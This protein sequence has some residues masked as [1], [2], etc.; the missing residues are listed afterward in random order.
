M[1]AGRIAARRFA[2]LDGRGA[3]LHGGRWSS[4]GRPLVHAAST[5]SLA[6]LEM[7][8]RLPT[9][10]VPADYAAIA[11]DVPDRPPPDEV[12]PESLP[13]WDAPDQLAS[14]ACGDAWL[15]EGRSL[16]LL[17]PALAVPQERNVL[18][19][20]RHPAMAGIVASPP[21]DIVWD[22][23]LLARHG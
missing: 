4:P 2:T 11:L 9:G 20:P 18:L 23:R 16:A 15:A 5:L 22:R 17:V 6:M 13:G 19:S 3:E 21:V 1:R 14:R 12:A 10:E 7:R 8:A